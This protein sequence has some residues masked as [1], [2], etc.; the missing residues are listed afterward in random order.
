M[1]LLKWAAA[2]A[3]ILAAVLSQAQPATAQTVLITGA[4]AGIGLEF[5][6]EYA[7]KSWT[8]IARR[9]S[10]R[11]CRCSRRFCQPNGVAVVMIHPGL[12]RTE[13]LMSLAPEVR[14]SK[15]YM[16]ASASVA[17]MIPT[18]DRLTIADSGHFMRYDGRP[19]PW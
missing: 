4:N 8:V 15:D 1:T 10:T 2:T 19:L 16:D 13:R 17:Q 6:R 14:T 11:K 18:I 9:H 5:A 12:V 3:A 7:A